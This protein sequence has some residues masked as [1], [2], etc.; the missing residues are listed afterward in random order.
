MNSHM[1]FSPPKR[2]GTFLYMGLTFLLLGASGSM[3]IFSLDQQGSGFFILALVG[4]ILLLVPIPFILYS[5]YSLSRARYELSREG[6]KIRWG[7]RSVDIPMP[8]IDWVRTAQALEKKPPLP[9]W[10]FSGILRGVINRPEFGEVEFLASDQRRLLL[11]GTRKKTYA[12]TPEDTNAFLKAFQSVFELG[13]IA[14]LKSSSIQAG[15][16][17][18]S[19]FKDRLARIFIL[20]NVFLL[21]ALL[22]TTTILISSRQTILFGYQTARIQSEPAPSNR[23]LLLP[24]LNF[25]SLVAVFT[26]GFYFFRSQTTRQLSYLTLASGLITPILFF[27]S[28]FFIQ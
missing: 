9:A 6:L 27:I 24:A 14:P 8:D 28:L 16:F 17:F 4:A 21:A 2:K 7:L 20:L 18:S 3:L 10:S 1:V 26:A 23:L 15:T 19:V 13:S 5:L 12:I 11:V 22:V 25:F